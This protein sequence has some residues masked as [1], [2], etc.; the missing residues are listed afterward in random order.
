MF[1]DEIQ[2]SRMTVDNLRVELAVSMGLV[3]LHVETVK[4]DL[5]NI[6]CIP[7]HSKVK[8]YVFSKPL[9]QITTIVNTLDCLSI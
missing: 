6:M 9:L 7:F 3:Y 1:K 5:I 8:V 4:I 2:Q